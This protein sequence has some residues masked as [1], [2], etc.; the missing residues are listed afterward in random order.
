MN[1]T[2]YRDGPRSVLTSS[3]GSNPRE[4][5]KLGISSCGKPKPG[6]VL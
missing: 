4:K 6:Y 1:K 2:N 5:T 3:L